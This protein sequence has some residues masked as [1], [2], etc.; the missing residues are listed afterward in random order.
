[1]A[2]KRKKAPKSSRRKPTDAQLER[3][4]KKKAKALET[5]RKKHEKRLANI[6]KG[7]APNSKR[8]KPKKRNGTAR[9]PLRRGTQ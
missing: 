9:R 3:A 5:E 8:A 4:A 1:M 6:E 2:A 7:K